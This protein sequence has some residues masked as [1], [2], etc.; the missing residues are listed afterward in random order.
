MKFKVGDQVRF[1]GNIARDIYHS[2][3]QQAFDLPGV[4]VAVD[5]KLPVWPYDVKFAGLRDTQGNDVLICAE[6][7]LRIA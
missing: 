1:V 7:E 3:Y 6:N 4:V 5:E 2:D